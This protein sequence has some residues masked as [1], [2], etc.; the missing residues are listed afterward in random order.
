[1]IHLLSTTSNEDEL[2]EIKAHDTCSQAIFSASSRDLS[3]LA[4]N[5]SISRIFPFLMAFESEIQT[6]NMC[7]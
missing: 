4:L 7:K 5:S 6:H 2:N 1:M 3:I